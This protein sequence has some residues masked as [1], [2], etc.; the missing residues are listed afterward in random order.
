MIY[1]ENRNLFQAVFKKAFDTAKIRH[2]LS[3][4][5]GYDRFKSQLSHSDYYLQKRSSGIWIENPG[6]GA[7]T[8]RKPR[9][10]VLGV[11]RQ[12]HGQYIADMPFRQ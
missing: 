8:Q 9:Q 1:E 4:N 10:T 5:L 11:Y 3:I 2:N 12:D 7:V 6:R